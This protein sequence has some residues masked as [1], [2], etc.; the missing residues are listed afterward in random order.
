MGERENGG[1]GEP[2][3]GG[4]GET[5]NE[6]DG[7]WR[8]RGVS[9]CRP[10]APLP[11]RFHSRIR[12]EVQDTGIGIPPEHVQDIFLPFQQLAD[13]RTGREGTGL[14]LAISQQLVRLMDS[15]LHVKSV[16]GQGTTFWFWLPTRHS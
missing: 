11:R 4:N 14:G 12:F 9:S 16:V 1:D 13:A 3:R 8:N 15:E 2:A 10:V 5:A 7:E 6:E